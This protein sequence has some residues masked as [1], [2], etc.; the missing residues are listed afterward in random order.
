MNTKTLLA[1]CIGIWLFTACTTNDDVIKIDSTHQEFVGQ[2]QLEKKFIN[3][4]EQPLTACQYSNHLEIS[5][6]N[7]VAVARFEAATANCEIEYL[8]V[9]QLKTLGVSTY[10]VEEIDF[11]FNNAVLKLVEDK[12]MLQIVDETTVI[13]EIYKKELL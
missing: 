11:A 6:Q 7:T 9:G 10:H 3:Q 5:T 12:L 13:T 2:W 1:A 8:Q 4:I